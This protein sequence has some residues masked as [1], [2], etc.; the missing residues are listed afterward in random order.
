MPSLASPTPERPD[1]RLGV[2]VS[3]V[4]QSCIEATTPLAIMPLESMHYL[5]AGTRARPLLPHHW[6]RT[7]ITSLYHLIIH[8]HPNTLNTYIVYKRQQNAV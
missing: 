1:A 2:G 4:L 3:M 8:H 5:V 6:S 7:E